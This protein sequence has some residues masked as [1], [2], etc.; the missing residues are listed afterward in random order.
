MMTA[1]AVGVAQ[2][3]SARIIASIPPCRSWPVSRAAAGV[4]EKGRQRRAATPRRAP[5]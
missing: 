4:S 2:G 3:V 1:L 5:E